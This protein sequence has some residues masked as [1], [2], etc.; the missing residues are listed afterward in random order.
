[1]TTQHIGD[2]GK[3]EETSCEEN[4]D[5]LEEAPPRSIERSLPAPNHFN[6]DAADLYF[7]WKHWVN[8]FELR[9][10]HRAEKQRGLHPAGDSV[11][12]S[13]P[14]SSED[15]QHIAR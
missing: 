15:I 14:A 1:M 8:A 7:E 12:L 10:R 5:Q 11:A 4:E 13:W 9:D 6:I 2:E 3:T